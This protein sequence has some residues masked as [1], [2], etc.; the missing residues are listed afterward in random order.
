ME[1]LRAVWSTLTGSL[2]FVPSLLVAGAIALAAAMIGLDAATQFHLAERWPLA[3]GSGAEGSRGV[4]S[5]IASSVITVAGVVFSITI[6]ALSLTA[7]QYSPRILRNF[8]SD[9]TTQVVLGTFVAIFVYCLVVLRTIRAPD[10]AVASFIPSLAVLLGILL[11]LVGTGLFVYFIHHVAASIQISSILSNVSNETMRVIDRLYPDPVGTGRDRSENAGAY[12]DGEGQRWHPVPALTN[13][14]IVR[15]DFKGLVDL[16]RKRGIVLRLQAAA[17]EF[18]I[19]RDVLVEASGADSRGEELAR[20]VN[21]LFTLNAQRTLDQDAAFGIQQVVDVALKAL[22]P[23]VNDSTTAVMCIDHL[24]AILTR[25]A[26]RRIGPPGG[27]D[28]DGVLQVR[29][30]PTYGSLVALAFDGIRRNARGN[31]DVLSQLAHRGCGLVAAT[32]HPARR[33]VAVLHTRATI[34]ALEETVRNEHERVAFV[35]EAQ[36]ALARACA[37]S[38]P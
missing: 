1:K 27:G 30:G 31:P 13:G 16:A 34:R 8:M 25:I 33:H 19:E 21:A 10:G 35:T 5:T 32:P 29:C 36:R 22:S 14:Y 2:W 18:V 37:Q 23:S 26:G 12:R 3:F 6:V 24:A 9:R 4:L 28:E 15:I 38:G 7:S 20:A 17:G 11:A